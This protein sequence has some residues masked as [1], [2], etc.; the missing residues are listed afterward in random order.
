MFMLNSGLFFVG[1]FGEGN[2]R[3]VIHSSPACLR[4]QVDGE[5]DARRQVQTGKVVVGCLFFLPSRI[6]FGCCNDKWPAISFRPDSLH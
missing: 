6:L 3:N 4:G 2:V 1:K 5:E